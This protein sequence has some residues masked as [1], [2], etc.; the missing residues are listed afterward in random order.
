VLWRLGV[1]AHRYPVRVGG[2]VRVHGL[3][4]VVRSVDWRARTVTT[5]TGTHD[6]V[7]CCDPDEPARVRTWWD[8]VKLAAAV[9]IGVIMLLTVLSLIGVVD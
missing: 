6:L 1:G 2:W 4:E 9:I 5:L 7:H 8:W 3:P